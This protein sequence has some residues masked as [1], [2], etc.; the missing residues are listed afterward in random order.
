VSRFDEWS[1][2]PNGGYESPKLPAASGQQVLVFE[3]WAKDGAIEAD[4]TLLSGEETEQGRIKYHAGLLVRLGPNSQEG[5][6]GGIGGYRKKYFIAKMKPGEW[7]LIDA[8]GSTESLQLNRNYKLRFEVTG[9][10]LRLF[11]G[12]VQMLSAVDD[13]YLSGQF[14]LRTRHTQAQ[15]DSIQLDVTKPLCFVVMPFASELAYVYRI[16]QET[17]ERAGLRCVRGDERTISR[18]IIDDI[19]ADI[20]TADLVLVDF[21]GKNPNVYYEAGL[22]DAWKK[23]WI[24]IAQSTD[25]LAFDVR[26]VRTILYANTMGADVKFR[27]DLSRAIRDT[28]SGR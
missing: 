26:H 25:D 8:A 10:Q 6:V 19:R 11:E 12:N 1:S 9:S 16:I 28:L 23:K 2:R 3:D 15:F 17:V 22:A 20:A 24:V 13:S 7:E 14:G 4:I 21:T 5:Y 18:P 27:E